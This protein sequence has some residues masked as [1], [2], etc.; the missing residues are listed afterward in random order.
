[1][2]EEFLADLEGDESWRDEPETALPRYQ[3]QIQ[4]IDWSDVP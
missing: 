1:M 2:V 4:L 3:V